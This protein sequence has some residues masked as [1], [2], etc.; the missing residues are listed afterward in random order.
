MTSVTGHVHGRPHVH[1]EVRTQ[2]RLVSRPDPDPNPNPNPN[3][4]PDPNPGA[5]GG[6]IL[7]FEGYLLIDLKRLFNLGD[8]FGGRSP[9]LQGVGLVP[10]VGGDVQVQPRAQE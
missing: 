9:K 10:K 4:N 8:G 7:I 1:R 2:P 3:P 6:H 5:D